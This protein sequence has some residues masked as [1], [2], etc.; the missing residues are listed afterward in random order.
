MGHTPSTAGTFLK[1]V[2]KNSGK[3]PETLSELFLEFPSRVQLGSP[4]P[5][6]SRHLKAPELFQKWFRGEPL[7]ADHGIPSSTGSISEL[8]PVVAAQNRT[9]LRGSFLALSNGKATRFVHE[10]G[11]LVNSLE[12][13]RKF[14][15]PP[16]FGHGLVVTIP[17]EMFTTQIRQNLKSA[18]VKITNAPK[19]L[20][21]F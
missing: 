17:T 12:E 13:R 9:E 7:R 1:K 4:K 10:P 2:R 6:N 18:T 19:N 8:N 5:Y 14:S 16:L 15:K 3:T 20:F 21:H 11:G